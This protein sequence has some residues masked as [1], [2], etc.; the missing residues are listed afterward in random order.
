MALSS[1]VPGKGNPPPEPDPRPVRADRPN[2]QPFP[3]ELE[4]GHHILDE[5]ERLRPAPP[6]HEPSSPHTR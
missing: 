4:Q 2:H 5:T 3:G 1:Y 6:T